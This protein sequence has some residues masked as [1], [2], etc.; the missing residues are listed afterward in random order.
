MF[1]SQAVYIIRETQ[2]VPLF[3]ID[4]TTSLSFAVT[5]FGS[6]TGE[7]LPSQLICYL[8]L[9]FSFTQSLC[10]KILGQNR[11]EQ[12]KWKKHLPTSARGLF[13]PFFSWDASW[14][15]ISIRGPPFSVG[16]ASMDLI[17]S[18]IWKTSRN[19]WPR[20]EVPS[21]C[22]WDAFWG[23]GRACATLPDVRKPKI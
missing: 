12:G 15:L 10:S 23:M 7:S 11:L 18:N 19:S 14:C 9:P 1:L 20:P 22:I 13:N 6:G 17:P 5:T 3:S 16:L 8:F 2:P 21:G 4:S